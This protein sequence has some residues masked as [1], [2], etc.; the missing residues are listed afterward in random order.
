M[1]AVKA[2]IILL[3]VIAA[4]NFRP[5]RPLPSAPPT[6]NRDI[7][8]IIYEYCAA[9]HHPDGSGPFSLLSYNDVKR[10]A[11][12]IAE[13]TASRYMPPWLPEPGYGHFAGERRLS[14]AQIALI[15]EWVAAGAIE[16]DAKDLPPAPQYRAGWQLGVPDLIVRMPEGYTLAAD[17]EDVFRNFVIPLPPGA[18]N[19]TRYVRAIEILPGN[20]R[21]VH[22]A[23]ILIDRSGAARR[24]D[25]EDEGV[26]FGGMDVSFASSSFEP[27][28]H[29]LFWKPGTAAWVEPEDMAWRLDKGTDL[30]LNMHLQPSGKPEAIQPSIGLYF[31]KRLPARFPMLLQLERD[32]AL[33]IPPGARAFTVSDEFRL[34]V[35]V[36]VLG[37][38][39]H[40]H[41]LGREIKAW[42]TLP[43]GERRPLIWIRDW[44]IDWQA[45]YRYEK[46]LEL[47]RGTVIHMRWTYDNSAANARNPSSP[48]RRV[49]AGNRSADEMS[50]LWIQVLARAQDAKSDPR[51]ELQRALMEAR[52]R[53]YP[54]DFTAHFNLAAALAT[55]GRAREA[56]VHYRAALRTRPGEVI[57]LQGLAAALQA[58]G[59]A[60]EAMARYREVLRIDPGY[61]DARYNLGNLLL[62]SGRI[63]EAIAE[64]KEVV[65]AAPEDAGAHNSLGSALAMQGRLD[66]AAENF[67]RSLRLK[68]ENPE[69][70]ANL[71]ILL[72]GRGEVA[73][74]IHHFE[75]ALRYD[76]QNADAHNELGVLF[77]RQGRMEEARAHFERAL[78]IDPEHAAARE[79]LKRARGRF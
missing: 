79:N 49:R 24:R 4:A 26:G 22:H 2:V 57:A 43:N 3:A 6:F 15:R 5:A 74:A 56:I 28:S 40:A 45:V 12:Q 34:P 46:P 36:E 69:A 23:N 11:R 65:R 44:N 72:A 38:Y 77:A 42:A 78:Q 18:V 1:L 32:G 20:R 17:G 52:L 73:R 35:D 14:D 21:V 75:Q 68:E 67:E 8:P 64:L 50:H 63:E 30:V 76:P 51:I 47:P 58:S 55:E 7:A 37:L 33:D 62:A 13:V 54:N 39:P 27:E 31:A 48:P 29:F 60:D 53:K 16:G 9:C 71:G 25:R 61:T 59:R 41:Y 66:E 70:H 10:R 19:E